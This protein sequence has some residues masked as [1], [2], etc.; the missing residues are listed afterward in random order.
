MKRNHDETGV[1]GTGLVLEG[2]QFSNGAVVVCW[3]ST[4]H[5]DANSISIFDSW[6]HFEE[7][8]ITPHPSNKTEITWRY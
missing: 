5:P 2:T 7:V 1:S 4:K 6:A 3:M 8:H